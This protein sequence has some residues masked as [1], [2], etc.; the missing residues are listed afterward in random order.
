MFESGSK[1]SR[2]RYETI[3]TRYNKERQVVSLSRLRPGE[4]G[5]VVGIR[6][7]DRTILQKLLAMTVIPGSRVKVELISP[8]VVFHVENTRVAVDHNVADKIEV[9]RIEADRS[10]LHI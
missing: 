5:E 1:I 8:V 10:K 6:K 7:A 9:L 2:I 3:E 4:A